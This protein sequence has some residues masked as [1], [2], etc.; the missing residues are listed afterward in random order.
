MLRDP[1]SPELS[2]NGKRPLVSS[3][4]PPPE[5]APSVKR[6]LLAGAAEDLNA[7]LRRAEKALLE[8]DYSAPGFVVLDSDLTEG[9]AVAWQRR[10]TFG[11]R[12]RGEWGLF[13]S[14]GPSDSSEQK[15]YNLCETPLDVRMKAAAN[16]PAL[17]KTLRDAHINQLRAL[18]A[19]THRLDAFLRDFEVDADLDEV[20]DRHLRPE[21]RGPR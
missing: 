10:L 14:E 12:E 19:A 15:T 2:E 5:P 18:H 21:D 4:P 1:K 6:S 9:Q 7:T 3:R 13:V 20:L 16:V 11:K 8:Y 17:V